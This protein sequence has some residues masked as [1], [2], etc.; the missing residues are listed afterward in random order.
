MVVMAVG[1]VEDNAEEAAPV[2]GW[3]K[4]TDTLVASEKVVANS[5][6]YN[7]VSHV[8]SDPSRTFLRRKVNQSEGMGAALE[9]DPVGEFQNGMGKTWIVAAEK[10]GESR[11]V[12]GGWDEKS[13]KAAESS[14]ETVKLD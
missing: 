9:P 13:T 6:K 4:T 3:V 10:S 5:A 14:M 1:K 7:W 2:D 12:S 8:M 11:I